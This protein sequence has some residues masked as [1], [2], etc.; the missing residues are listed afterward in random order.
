M[1]EPAK[2]LYCGRCNQ[3]RYFVDGK[4]E[5]CSAYRVPKVD[6]YICSK[7]RFPVPENVPCPYCE[8]EKLRAAPPQEMAKLR[9]LEAKF[10]SQATHLQSAK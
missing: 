5:V 3:R 9:E 4:C 8:L 7:H 10:L 1:T 2:L 6:D